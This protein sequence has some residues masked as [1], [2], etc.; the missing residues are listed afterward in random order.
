MESNG[1]R[2]LIRLTIWCRP[3]GA[4]LSQL[5]V[6]P[7]TCIQRPLHNEILIEFAECTK[8]R[9]RNSFVTRVSGNAT[10]SLE[11]SEE[12][13]DEDRG[14]PKQN[15]IPPSIK[16][17]IPCRVRR[18]RIASWEVFVSELILKNGIEQVLELPR[19]PN[20]RN[21][22]SVAIATGEISSLRSVAIATYWQ[23]FAMPISG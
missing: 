23:I 11:N 21:T 3:R 9:W 2:V 12:E 1:R 16:I 5:R 15:D 10:Y 7:P 4:G 6:L 22:S 14:K 17:K 18:E 19:R 13:E 8:S 20:G